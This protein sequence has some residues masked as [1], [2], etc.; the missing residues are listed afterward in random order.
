MNDHILGFKSFEDYF[1]TIFGDPR[2][3][4]LKIIIIMTA[5]LGF[6]TTFIEQWI[7]SPIWTLVLLT[8]IVC[9]DFVAAVSNNLNKEGFITEKAIKLPFVLLSYWCFLAIAYNLPA[10]NRDLGIDG[11]GPE[12]FN[13]FSKSL[14][15]LCLL[16]NLQ[17]LLRHSSALGLLPKPIANFFLRWIDQHKTRLQSESEDSLVKKDATSER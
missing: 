5:V 1:K 17:S 11:I 14:Y 13:I 10:L 9:L 4:N 16:I 12:V 8:I 15:W 7:W 6:L 2:K 3:V